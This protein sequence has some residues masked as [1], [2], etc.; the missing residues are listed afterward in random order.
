MRPTYG[1]TGLVLYAS[2]NACFT[3]R[4][5]IALSLLPAVILG[6][7]LLLVNLAVPVSWFWVVYLVQACNLSSAAGAVYL[8]CK[9]CRMQAGILVRGTGARTTVYEKVG[10]G[11]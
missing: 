6:A 10:R 8:A 2:S 5:Y 9:L 3:K 7:L 1:F 11:R 4:G